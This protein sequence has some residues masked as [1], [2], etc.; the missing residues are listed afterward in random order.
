MVT[1]A[2][3][4][5][6]MKRCCRVQEVHC[7]TLCWQ[8]R[9]QRVALWPGQT[10]ESKGL[11]GITPRTA[12]LE[13]R[14][15]RAIP[16]EDRSRGQV[17]WE[18]RTHEVVDWESK[19]HAA[20]CMEGKTPKEHIFYEKTPAIAICKGKCQG[21]GFLKRKVKTVR[22]MGKEMNMNMNMNMEKGRGGE[23]TSGTLYKW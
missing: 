12:A 10:L 21:E 5:V 17:D 6:M 15:Q 18:D 9:V 19:I 2:I 3:P 8:N 16:W 1:A 11:T 4:T 13:D 23:V 20:V 22:F 14:I 7:G